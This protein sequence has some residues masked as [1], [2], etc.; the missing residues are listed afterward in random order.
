MVSIGNPWLI[1]IGC[2]RFLGGL[3]LVPWGPFGTLVGGSCWN[4]G[5]VRKDRPK[6][7]FSDGF[8]LDGSNKFVSP[9]NR[10]PVQRDEDELVAQGFDTKR[11]SVSPPKNRMVRVV[12]RLCFFL[13][14]L[15]GKGKPILALSLRKP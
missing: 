5:F 11:G 10:R 7:H 2:P 3:L 12:L 8:Y 15:K 6:H 9:G 4:R 1:L 14:A 13:V